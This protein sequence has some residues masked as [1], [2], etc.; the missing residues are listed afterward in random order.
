MLFSGP[1]VFGI[2]NE[3]P[4]G[5]TVQQAAYI[6]RHGSRLGLNVYALSEQI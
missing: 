6:V 1:N 4:K 3:V 2:S 5:C